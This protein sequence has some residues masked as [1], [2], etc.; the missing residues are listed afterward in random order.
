MRRL[1]VALSTIALLLPAN[2]FARGK[3]D[4]TKEFEQHEW[5]PI[6]LGPLDLSITKAVVYL[7]LGSVLTMVLGIVLMRWRLNV[8]PD[9]RQTLLCDLL[10]CDVVDQLADRLAAA[11]LA[12]RPPAHEDETESDRDDGGDHQ[13]GDGLRDRQV[14]RPEMDRDPLVLLE[15]DRRVE[16][17]AGRGRARQRE[18]EQRDGEQ[19]VPHFSAPK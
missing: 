14:E 10:L 1:L 17:A 19:A 15:L 2:A 18:R 12:A 6:H 11:V 3:F 9:T 4:P 13:I 8:E 5:V 16:L 7:M